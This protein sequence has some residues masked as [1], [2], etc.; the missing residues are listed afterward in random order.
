M[1]HVDAVTTKVGVVVNLPAGIA[2]MEISDVTIYLDKNATELAI[3]VKMPLFITDLKFIKRMIAAV[4]PDGM[5]MYSEDEMGC[6]KLNLEIRQVDLRPMAYDDM[7]Y[8]AR[9]PLT[10]YIVLPTLMPGD[11]NVIHGGQ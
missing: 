9:I 6:F 2:T 4:S 7:Y 11:W 5:K 8:T 1:Y 3:Q 10:G